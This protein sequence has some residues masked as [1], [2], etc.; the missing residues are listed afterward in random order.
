MKK[1]LVV[2]SEYGY[3][4]EELIGPL[5][6]LDEAGYTSVF[7]T[8]N[9]KRPRA[10]PVSMDPGFMDPPLGRSVTNEYYAKKTKDVDDSDRLSKPIN[11]AAWFPE[12][13]YFSAPNYLRELEKYNNTLDEVQASL[14]EY[15]ALLLVGG[16]GP[17]VDMVNNQRLH[18]VILGFHKLGLPVAAECYGVT[19]LA[20]ARD[21]YSRKSLIWGKHVTGHPLEY[22]YHDGTGFYNAE[23]MAWVDFN[24][25]P[26]PYPLEYILRDAVGPDGMYHGNVG[27]KTS[28]IV[29]F[30]F[31]TGRS[32]ASSRLVGDLLVQVL[33]KGLTRYG[34]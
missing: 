21:W 23:K 22:D 13:P 24:M 14:K 34:W 11:L 2:L 19:C 4:G 20:F 31:I 15:D 30:P 6:A 29:D 7:M 16:S 33:S 5:D 28:A 32:T 3:W 8:P 18:D 12:R 25:G 17:I 9:G 26:P 10:L 27:R 1:V